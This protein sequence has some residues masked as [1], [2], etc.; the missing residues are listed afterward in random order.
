M[1]VRQIESPDNL[2]LL[3]THCPDCGYQVAIAVWCHDPGCCTQSP[4]GFLVG[5]LASAQAAAASRVRRPLSGP[6][7][8]LL[9]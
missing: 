8:A 4:F 6:A 3:R 2:E 7:A 9:A 5:E 1:T